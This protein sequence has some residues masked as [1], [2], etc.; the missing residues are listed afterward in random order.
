MRSLLARR[1]GRSAPRAARHGRA[2]AEDGVR[3]RLARARRGRRLAAGRRAA[4]RTRLRRGIGATLDVFSRF[5]LARLYAAT[6]RAIPVRRRSVALLGTRKARF[7]RS[8][9]RSRGGRGAAVGR[10]IVTP[11]IGARI[12]IRVAALVC[13]RCGCG[14][15]IVGCT[16]A[17]AA[18][19]A[20][21]TTFAATFLR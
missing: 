16:V 6:R 1:W 13:S 8:R 2:G 11:S 12:A 3:L 7:C 9:G 21:T 19:A 5:L 15:R 10:R 14:V 4:R 17:A 18:T 20:T